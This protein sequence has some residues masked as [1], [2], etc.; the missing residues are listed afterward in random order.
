VGPHQS[1]LSRLGQELGASTDDV[2]PGQCL[3]TPPRTGSAKGEVRAM[4]R[5][6][7]TGKAA[8][9]RR[10]ANH[11]S[12]LFVRLTGF[13]SMSNN[14]R[15]TTCA[16]FPSSSRRAAAREGPART[17]CWGMWNA[18]ATAIEHVA[19]QLHAEGLSIGHKAVARIMHD[20]GLQLRP[21]SS[22]RSND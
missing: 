16:E 11:R 13:T 8:C 20:N 3:S 5:I 19:H 15:Q 17:Y 1:E 14:R 6:Q 21:F 22:F 12:R 18:R 2:C 4:R 7:T 9:H 10:A